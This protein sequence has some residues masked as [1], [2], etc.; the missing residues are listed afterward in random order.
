MNIVVTSAMQRSFL[1][2]SS[3]SSNHAIKKAENEKFKKDAKSVGQI[4]FSS[5]KR[6][7]PLVMNHFGLRAGHFNAVLKELASLL[8]SLLTPCVPVDAPL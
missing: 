5:I 1:S 8:A 2:L 3:K 4:Q 6:F 7:I